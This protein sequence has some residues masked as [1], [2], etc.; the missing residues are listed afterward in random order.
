MH[1]KNGTH[2]VVPEVGLEEALTEQ[3]GELKLHLQSGL[4][5][6]LFGWSERILSSVSYIC[7]TANIGKWSYSVV[8]QNTKRNKTKLRSLY[9]GKRLKNPCKIFLKRR[10]EKIPTITSPEFSA[11]LLYHIPMPITNH[12][13]KVSS[14]GVWL[15]YRLFTIIIFYFY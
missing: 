4:L 1:R 10:R 15:S 14:S 2:C 12:R 13:T 3:N 8:K 9:E 7:N 5:Q 6:S 11:Y